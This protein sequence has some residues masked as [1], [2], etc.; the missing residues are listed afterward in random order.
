MNEVSHGFPQFRQLPEKYLK[1]GR[2]RYLKLGGGQAYDR[3]RD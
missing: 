3:S 2:N 1:F